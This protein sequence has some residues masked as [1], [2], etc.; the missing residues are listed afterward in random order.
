MNIKPL[1]ILFVSS[2]NAAR[3]ILA[4]AILRQKGSARFQA[5]SA[6]YKPLAHIH[7]HAL[8]LLSAEGIGIDGLH[9]K[10]WNEFFAAAR[11]IKI[12]VIVTLS[13][14]AR[15]NIPT[16]PGDPVRVHWAVDDPLSAEKA[17]VMEWKFRKCLNTL[18]A[19]IDALVRTR[20]A[21]SPCELFLQMKDIGMVV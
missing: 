2:G 9:T 21:A 14:D 10:G 3:S 20:V 1:N 17:D 8:Q 15:Q 4:E 12:E 11:I 18:E 19:R 7:S 16:W 6:G 13:E 5:R